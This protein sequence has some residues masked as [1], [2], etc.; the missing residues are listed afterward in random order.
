MRKNKT[1]SIRLNEDEFEK[2]NKIATKDG[3]SVSEFV[4]SKVFANPYLTVVP[5][6]STTTTT[7]HSN[8]IWFD[9]QG[10]SVA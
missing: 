10:G 5:P 7:T 9:F 3:K 6:L 4:R 8:V 1:V 2:L